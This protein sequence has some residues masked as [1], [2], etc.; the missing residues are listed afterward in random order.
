M[1]LL[2]AVFFSIMAFALEYIG[3]SWVETIFGENALLHGPGWLILPLVAGFVGWGIGDSLG[4][5]K[6]QF[7]QLFKI[8]KLNKRNK[9]FLTTAIIW[10]SFIFFYILL[11]KSFGEHPPKRR[12][13][14]T[15]IINF[16]TSSHY[17]CDTISLLFHD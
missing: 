2:M 7:D 12:M 4:I 9:I 1:R 3:F 17:F 8:R 10:E 11:T 16:G 6:R 15:R 13:V 14:N 5:N